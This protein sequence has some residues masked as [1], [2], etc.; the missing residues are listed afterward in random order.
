[1]AARPFILRIVDIFQIALHIGPGGKFLGIVGLGMLAIVIWTTVIYLL[2]ESAGSPV[3][4]LVAGMI[5]VL[6]ELVRQ[7]P[8]SVQGIG[9][10]EASFA[11][12]FGL[13]GHSPEEGFV[14]G[15]AAYLAIGL[16]LCLAGA[17]GAI[18]PAR[19]RKQSSRALNP[20]TGA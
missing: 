13:I 18:L 16:A 15:A 5:G 9:V 3:P 6:V 14:V 1:M 4:F 20:G 2:A 10:R 8:V 19:P 7:I 17:L 12:L 11:Y